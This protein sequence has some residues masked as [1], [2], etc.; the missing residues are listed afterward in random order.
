MNT[1]LFSHYLIVARRSLSR[2]RTQSIISI[3]G[4]AVGFVCLSLSA[5][6]IRY[7][8]T[9]NTSV[10]GY[11]DIYALGAVL[12]GNFGALPLADSLRPWTNGLRWRQRPN[13]PF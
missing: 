10:P 2:D 11:K 6:W 12:S 8:N 9:Y 1:S 13:M 7:D 5:L 4:L 3:V